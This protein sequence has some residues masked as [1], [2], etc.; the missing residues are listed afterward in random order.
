LCAAAAGLKAKKAQV[1]EWIWDTGAAVDTVPKAALVGLDQFCTKPELPNIIS[2]AHGN[3]AVEEE[4]LLRLPTLGEVCR[5]L[6][7]GGPLS[8][9]PAILCVGWR[10]M[11][12]GYDFHWPPF[13][14][15][16]ITLPSGK[17][18]FL[19]VENYV[20]ILESKAYTCGPKAVE[21]SAKAQ[22][23]FAA[24]RASGSGGPGPPDV[25]VSHG[26]SGEAGGSP[27]GTSAKGGGLRA[28]LLRKRR[29]GASTPGY[30]RRCP[31]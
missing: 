30:R 15:P 18:V 14:K 25:A 3:R 10:C 5:P 20:P 1:T 6:V 22:F 21:R 16:V 28:P 4:I 31:S 24:P 19:P 7:L 11:E 17:Q 29:M 27:P 23:M 12:L 13:G 9:N 8:I 2:T 26:G